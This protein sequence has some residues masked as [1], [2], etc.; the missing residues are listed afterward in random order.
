VYKGTKNI[1][2]FYATS[3][4]KKGIKINKNRFFVDIKIIGAI[5]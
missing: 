2:L 4:R 1:P 3:F 5:Y